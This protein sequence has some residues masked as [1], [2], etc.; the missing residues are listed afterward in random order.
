MGAKRKLRS[1]V[2]PAGAASSLDGV[3]GRPASGLPLVGGFGPAPRCR[4]VG[5][6]DPVGHEFASDALRRS[7]GGREGHASVSSATTVSPLLMPSLRR[8][9]AGMT[10][11]PSA[12]SMSLS[13][14]V[15]VP[16]NTTFL[17]FWLML[18]KPPAPASRGPNLETLRLPSRSACAYLIRDRSLAFAVT[19]RG[20][21]H[22]IRRRRHGRPATGT[23]PGR[24]RAFHGPGETVDVPTFSSRFHEGES[25]S[26]HH[27]A[28]AMTMDCSHAFSFADQHER[29][30]R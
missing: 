27:T 13:P 8:T 3:D 22:R 7:D 6:T 28:V 14:A 29:I 11:L 30:D 19:A 21:H 25:L 20:F 12:T 17:A 26:C 2:G 9:C 16:A 5:Q 10:S 24:F 1:R 23:D 4:L 15:N 18:M